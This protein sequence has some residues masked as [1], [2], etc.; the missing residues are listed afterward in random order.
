MTRSLRP[1]AILWLLSTSPSNARADLAYFQK[2]GELQAP[3]SV[4]GKQVFIELPD[5]KHEFR[6]DDFIKLV[7]G[8]APEREWR[9]RLQQAQPAG[10]AA[11]YAA[12]WWAIENGL[13][14]E[15]IPELRAL[16]K[17]DPKHL[18]TARMV[19]VLEKLNRSCAE[20]QVAEFRKALGVETTVTAGPHV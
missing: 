2:G 16:H 4:E 3:L 17:L 8:F 13:T 20:P 15:A 5:G 19:A 12:T 10:F 18:Q 9:E 1:L 6:R 7:P 14:T 11:R